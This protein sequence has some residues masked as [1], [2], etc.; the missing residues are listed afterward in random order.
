MAREARAESKLAPL[1]RLA[2]KGLMTFLFPALHGPS[3]RYQ[4]ENHYMR[5]PGPKWRAKHLAEHIASVPPHSA[6]N[7][8]NI[9][10]I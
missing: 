10:T 3:A 6:T 2:L 9:P 7:G 1:A 8:N 4:P 5:G